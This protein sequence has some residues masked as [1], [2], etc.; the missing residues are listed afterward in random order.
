MQK[1][2]NAKKS[3]TIKE[4]AQMANVSIGTV[5]R[6]LNGYN[7]KEKNKLAIQDAIHVLDYKMNYIAKSMK[8][9]N[10]ATIG[11][12]V[13]GFDEFSS[14]VISKMAELLRK[15]RYSLVTLHHNNDV[16][17]FEEAFDFFR[18]RN[19]D[20]IA[21]ANGWYKLSPIVKYMKQEKPIVV[22]NNDISELNID[23][24]FVD[25]FKASY[26]AVSYLTQMGHKRIGC[27][28]GEMNDSSARN[29][30]EGY[31]AALTDSNL[32]INSSYIVEGNWSPES[33]YQA[34][35]TF[36]HRKPRIT[37]LFCSNYTITMGV[38][39]AMK[40]L[41]LT[42]PDDI[43]LIT[44]DDPPFLE[45]LAPSMT[46]IEQPIDEIARLATGFLIDRLNH[47]YTGNG[48]TVFL[49]ANLI[50]RDSVNHLS[51]GDSTDPPR[52]A[53]FT[54]QSPEL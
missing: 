6:F 14:G 23:K 22:F 5:S 7:V 18:D 19:V 29:R 37:A 15:Q 32:E 28:T 2:S 10:T 8:T 16:S 40:E 11:L 47:E 45:L 46:A 43:S 26:R 50:I 27:I 1:N 33:G 25:D 53:N 44:Y 42:I 24:V 52:Q 36:Y 31:K 13:S 35:K 54:T 41:N 49:E 51:S 9:K 12:L 3:N 21:M 20:G 30:F 48:R 17:I 38:I 34:M 39:K 4:V